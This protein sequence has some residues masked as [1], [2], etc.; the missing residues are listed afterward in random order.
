MMQLVNSFYQ[1]VPPAP[2]TFVMIDNYIYLYHTKTL[3]ALPTFPEQLQDSQQIQ[4]NSD[5]PLTSSAPIYAFA[6]A[7]PRSFSVSLSLHRD[8]MTQINT[9]TSNLN[10]KDLDK[11]DY[12]DILIK[13]MQA[14][15]LPRYAAA[16]KMVDPPMVAIRFGNELYC[17]GIIQGTLT[18]TYSGPILRTNK[19][20]QVNID[21]T[22]NEIDPYDAETVMRAGSFRGLS[23][24]LERN[25]WKTNP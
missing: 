12:V 25:I 23:T 19:Y 24:T 1:Y 8:M 6:N 15:A 13:Q 20:A 7:G 11:E 14:A 3:I 9:S 22:I 16:E 2:K 4:F 18:T 21:F 10:V 17:K 5:S